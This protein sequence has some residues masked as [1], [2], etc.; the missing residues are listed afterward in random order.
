MRL[1]ILGAPG[2][3]KGTQAKLLAK[4]LHLKHISTGEL[5]RKEYEKK[6]KLGIQAYTYWSKG[7]LVP[8]SVSIA[9]TEKHL[10]LDNYLLIN[11]NNLKIDIKSI[12][13]NSAIGCE[14]TDSAT[15]P[16]VT[17]TRL[18]MGNIY[19][20]LFVTSPFFFI[21]SLMS[22]SCSN[23]AAATEIRS[24]VMPRGLAE[25]NN[26]SP[27]KSGISKVKTFLSGT[28]AKVFFDAGN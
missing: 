19:G 22:G 28:T 23:V 8:N 13:A 5:L 17:L 11:P 4:K 6:T 16:S 21:I 26:Q 1:I 24:V 25:S 14:P 27:A 9:I 12:L 15:P 7:N 2:S 20:D 18:P 10:P 3:G